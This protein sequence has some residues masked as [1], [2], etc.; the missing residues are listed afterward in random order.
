MYRAKTW[1][2]EHWLW[3]G[4]LK[5]V[6]VGNDAYVRLIEDG[7]AV[8]AEAP[9]VEG[10]VEPVTDS[11]RYFVLKIVD[12]ASGKSAFIGI[13]FQD[14]N[15]AFD[16][17]LALNQHKSWIINQNKLKDGSGTPAKDY[18]LKDGETITV[19]LK[20]KATKKRTNGSAASGAISSR[21]SRAS[22]ASSLSSGGGLLPPPPS[23]ASSRRRR[24]AQPTQSTQPA[25]SIPPPA[26]TSTT[27]PATGSND[28]DWGSFASGTSP[29]DAAATGTAPPTSTTTPVDPWAIF[30]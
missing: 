14:R 18:S 30:Q 13:G 23:A 12:A 28:I 4:E 5:V 29:A 24:G 25:T 27:T 7:G 22:P 3:L 20:H 10:A 1:D 17:N 9:V 26:S 8:F 16:F 11:S 6:A 15:Y 19:S 21:P 2:L